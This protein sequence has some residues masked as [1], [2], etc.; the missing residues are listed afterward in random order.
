ML[1]V[2]IEWMMEVPEIYRQCYD[3]PFKASGY[4]TNLIKQQHGAVARKMHTNISPVKHC[5]LPLIINWSMK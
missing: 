2:Q 1:V 4:N 3:K 5:T